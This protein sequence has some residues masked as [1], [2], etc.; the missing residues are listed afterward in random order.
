M[1]H[2]AVKY[3]GSYHVTDYRW[4]NL[5]DNISTTQAFAETSG[6]LTDRYRRKPAF[7][8]YRGLIRRFGAQW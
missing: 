3:A 6:L 7:F 4:F 1:V 2:A 8:A 5:R